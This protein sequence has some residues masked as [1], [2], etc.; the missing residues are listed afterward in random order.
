VYGCKLKAGDRVLIHNASGGVGSFAVQIAKS[1]GAY[2]IGTAS[3]SKAVFVKSLGVDEFIDYRTQ[4]FEDVVDE[5]DSVLAA[6][7]GDDILQRSLQIIKSGGELVSLLD[8]VDIAFAAEK[9]VN[10]QRWWVTPSAT[11]L[12]SIAALIDNGQMSVHID[13]IF[14]L[15]DVKQAHALSESQR[16]RGKIVLQ[17]IA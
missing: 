6:V 8:D 3:A 15:E 13:K 2:V 14:P 7:G 12:Q 10:A 9:N 5:V 1:L 16:T 4:R 17:V 11:D